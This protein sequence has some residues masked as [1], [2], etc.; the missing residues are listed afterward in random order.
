VEQLKNFISKRSNII[1]VLLLAGMFTL[2]VT[3][4]M[5]DSAIDDEVAHIPAGYSYLKYHDYRLNPEHPPLIKELAAT[6]LLFMNLQFPVTNPAWTTEVNGQWDVGWNFIYNYGNNADEILFWARLPI[7]LLSLVCG[8]VLY[9]FVRNRFGIAAGLFALFLYVLE[10][11]IMAHSRLVTTDL[12]ATAFMLFSFITFIRWLEA[13]KPK[14]MVVATVFFALAQL[15][16]FSSVLLIPFYVLITAVALVAWSDKHNWKQRF[17]TYFWGLLGIGGGGFALIILC[18]LPAVWSMPSNVQDAL[19]RGSLVT[20]LWHP[21]VSF[22]TAING[23]LVMRAIVQYLLGVA[24]VLGRITGGNTTYLFG[25]VTNQS[26][27]WYFPVTYVMKTPVALLILIAATFGTGVWAYLRKTPFKVWS[28]LVSYAR[29]HHVEST[30]FAFIIFYGI[31]ALRS[32]LDLG[33]RY[34]L[35]IFPFVF[36]LVAVKT[37]ELVRRFDKKKVWAAAGLAILMVYYLGANL[38]AYPSYLPYVNE[39]FG[40]TPA[41]S[42]YLSDSSVD[43]GQDLIRLR[44]YVKANPQIKKIA[45]DYFGGGL[46]QY[47]FCDRAYDATGHLIQTINGYDCSHSVYIPWRAQYGLYHGYMAVSETYLTNDIY[48]AAQRGD[49][50]YAALRKMKPIAKI[51]G[52]IYV[53][54]VQ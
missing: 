4:M 41:A 37:V 51:G 2:G 6:P 3:S 1:A 11:N 18:Y 38:F 28:N 46:P 26:F 36:I 45:V 21:L 22:L 35:P 23:S 32:N 10:P 40:G 42:K 17:R 30:S 47:Y 52:S 33:I 54:H 31:V 16:K 14:N 19:V 34:I 8:W 27:F 50:G 12:G 48:Y 20:P 39:L 53:Y 15:A 5:H 29:N 24:M 7:L 13:P 49:Q 9:R 43:W 44:D 25:Q